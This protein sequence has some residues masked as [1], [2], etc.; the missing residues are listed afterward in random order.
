MYQTHNKKTVVF[1]APP[2]ACGSVPMPVAR[3][4]KPRYGGMHDV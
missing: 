3:D 2:S 4:F 1:Q